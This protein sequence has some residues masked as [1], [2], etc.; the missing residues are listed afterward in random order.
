MDIIVHE[1]D[2]NHSL[3]QPSRINHYRIFNK[4][5]GLLSIPA[6][7]QM[8]AHCIHRSTSKLLILVTTARH[9]INQPSGTKPLTTSIVIAGGSP[10]IDG[11]IHLRQERR[12]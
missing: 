3:K 6:T 1:I 9:S 5:R 7:N 10:S 4:Q 12:C 8:L 2:I 11:R